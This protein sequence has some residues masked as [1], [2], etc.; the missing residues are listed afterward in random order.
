LRSIAWD[1][2]STRPHRLSS[3]SCMGITSDYQVVLFGDE[4]PPPT[5]SGASSN[6]L[7]G[8]AAAPMSTLFQDLFGQSAFM[9]VSNEPLA[10]ANHARP[11][12][13]SNK[14][15][16]E[17]LSAPAHLLPPVGTVFDD[18]MERFLQP[19]PIED[20]SPTLPPSQD[21]QDEDVLM[22]IDD[23]PQALGKDFVDSAEISTLVKIFRRNVVKR[24]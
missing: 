9:D 23:G 5:E 11:S 6:N 15:A 24:L 20:V 16:S 12:R 21:E 8:V 3:F 7:P 13:I 4:V 18:I 17:V 14:G 2:L 19:R 10:S 22:Q 1:S